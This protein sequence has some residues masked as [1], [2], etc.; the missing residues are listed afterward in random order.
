MKSILKKK[1]LAN[2]MEPH[3]PPL[4]ISLLPTAFVG[5]HPVKA[6]KPVSR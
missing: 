3:Y 6:H 2:L 1:V 4:E 5:L